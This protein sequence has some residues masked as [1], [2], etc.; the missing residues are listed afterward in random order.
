MWLVYN[1]PGHYQKPCGTTRF[2]TAFPRT[3]RLHFLRIRKDA[4]LNKTITCSFSTLDKLLIL[5]LTLFRP[6]LQYASIVWNSIMSTDA[7]TLERIQREFA[8][9]C[10]YRFF[11]HDHVTY[12]DFLKFLKLHTLHDRRLSWCIIFH[13]CLFSFKMIRHF[14]ILLVSEFLLAIS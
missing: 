13:S 2:K 12:E 1:P 11:I 3:Y 5:Y 10:Q 9:I 14:W 7:K 4:E 8:A 6:K